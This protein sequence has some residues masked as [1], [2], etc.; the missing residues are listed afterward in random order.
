MDDYNNGYSNGN[1]EQNGNGY[2]PSSNQQEENTTYHYSYR[3]TNNENASNY[4]TPPQSEGAPQPI[5]DEEKKHKRANK[6]KTV[7][8]DEFGNPVKPKKNKTVIAIVSIIIA[9]VIVGVIGIAYA[10]SEDGSNAGAKR[11]EEHT[12]EL[13][14]RI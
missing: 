9:C 10:V 1:N 6:E 2:N 13:Q 11:S 5:R 7:Q 12:S 8:Y 3:N 4:Y 14:S